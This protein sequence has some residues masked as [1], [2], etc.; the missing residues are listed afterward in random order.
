MTL[1]TLPAP[2]RRSKGRLRTLVVATALAFGL[3]LVLAKAVRAETDVPRLK[4]DVVVASDLVTLGDFFE[5]AGPKAGVPVFRAPDLGTTGA[6]ETW[7]IVEAAR[8]QGLTRLDTTG[9]VRVQVTREA[10][11]LAAAD[12]ERLIAR[13]V[14]RQGGVADPA[15]V[16]LRFDQ[17]VVL[18]SAD[19]GAREPLRLQGV[20]WQQA[21]GRFDATLLVDRGSAV[22]RVRLRGEADEAV[23]VAV[24][25]RN[26][27]RGDM[28]KGEDV[29]V[30]RRPKR[31][32]GGQKPVAAEEITAQTARRALR[33]GQV[34][35]A[36]DLAPPRHVE[37]GGPVVIV[38]EVPGIVVTARGQA[39]E[40]GTKGD[41]VSV[42]NQQSKRVVQATVTGPG[43]V[44]I[45]TG[46][47]VVADTRMKP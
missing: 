22:E 21:T 14:A 19:P 12:A 5:N 20:S 46:E 27:A 4:A 8:A 35:T 38:Y 28:L 43:R 40:S 31:L 1:V 42:L 41:T 6:V 15:M 47:R 9:L 17:A 44:A 3:A 33:A 45:L 34:L 25:T 16:A 32:L 24:L 37:R 30:E 10:M 2:R 11:M 39:L 18:P 26:L 13:E 7:R 23:D 36:Q 29:A